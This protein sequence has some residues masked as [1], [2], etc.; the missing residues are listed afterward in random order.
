MSEAPRSGEAD[1]IVAKRRNG[2]TA[3]ITV[4]FLGHYSQFTDMSQT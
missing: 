4:A 2:P 1:L 3:T